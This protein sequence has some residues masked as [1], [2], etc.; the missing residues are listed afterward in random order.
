M[1]T[2]ELIEL[3][4]KNKSSRKVFCGVIPLDQIP[5]K[6]IAKECAFIV[7]TH[8]SDKPGEHWFSVYIPK[9]GPIEY[10]DSYG[11]PPYHEIIYKF[12]KYNKRPFIYNRIKIQHDSSQNCGKFSLFYIYYRSKGY[13]MKEFL[14]LFNKQYLSYNDRILNNLYNRI[15]SIVSK[16]K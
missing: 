11:L 4:M 12:F 1:Y 9:R 13:T 3:L 8:E 16:S 14:N 10:F 2:E 6:K 5:L 15:N 7:N